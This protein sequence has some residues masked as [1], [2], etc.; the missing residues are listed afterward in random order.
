MTDRAEETLALLNEELKGRLE[1]Q[2]ATAARL[3]TKLT[4]VIG[5]VVAAIPLL[6]ARQIELIAGITA[7]VALASVFVVALDGLRPRHWRVVPEPQPLVD[8]F[9]GRTP[10]EVLGALVGTRVVAFERNRKVTRHK[11]RRLNQSIAMLL[12]AVIASG[13]S[14][15]IRTAQ[16]GSRQGIS[17]DQRPTIRD[18]RSP[19]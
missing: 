9:S 2:D 14:L 18:A 10:Y 3:D 12:M 13:I 7:V 6:L 4:L 1:R 16:N 8:E 19:K 17:V 5:F 11:S 15:Q